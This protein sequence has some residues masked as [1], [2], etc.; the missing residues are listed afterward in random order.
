[1]F[2]HLMTEG[3][4]KFYAS[5]D[6][7]GK[8]SK[9]LEVFYNPVMKFNRDVS[10]LLLNNSGLKNIQ[11]ADIMAGSGV[12]SIRFLLELKKGIVDNIFVNDYDPNFVSTF[13]KNLKASGVKNTKHIIIT[14]EDANLSLLHA[15]GV[16]YVDVDPFGSPNDFLDASIVRVS[17]NGILGITATDTASLSGSHFDTCMRNYWARPL[18]TGMMHETGIRILI[19]K[20]QMLGAQHD[21]ALIPIYSYFKDYYFRIFFKCIKGKIVSDN[22]LKQHKYVLYCPTCMNMQISNH[23]N[24]V[25]DLCAAN[26]HSTSTNS[27]NV[28]FMEYSGPMWTGVLQDSNLAEKIFSNNKVGEYNKF[29]ETIM[30]ESKGKCNEIFGFYD[31]HE[32]CQHYKLPIPDYSI[33][34]KKLIAKGYLVSRTHFRLVGLKTDARINVV[35]ET[36]KEISQE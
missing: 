36:I 10:V 21:K 25:C 27:K 28:K 9:E 7:N 22:V 4:A 14:N 20:I 31:I 8:I 5:L 29:L 15:K 3:K 32:I 11:L 26:S 24:V 6:K 30:L 33:L 19:R 34:T 1:M 17:R 23:N 18:H 16:D 13:K 2:M 12:R 35:V